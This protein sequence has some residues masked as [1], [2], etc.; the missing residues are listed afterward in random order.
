V[1]FELR[2]GLS[3]LPR[4]GLFVKRFW[5]LG[6]GYFMLQVIALVSTIVAMVQRTPG[7]HRTE[8]EG[9]FRFMI[10]KIGKF[11]CV[12]TGFCNMK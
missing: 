10:D 3:I 1:W 12:I 5:V 6:Q 7:V 9:A 11:R 2:Y 4:W 8:P